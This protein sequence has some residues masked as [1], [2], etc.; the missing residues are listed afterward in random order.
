MIGAVISLG[1]TLILVTAALLALDAGSRAGDR[2]GDVTVSAVMG[3]AAQADGRLPVIVATVRNPGDAP[4]LVGL[5]ARR[6]RLPAWFDAGMSV[7]APRRTARRRL[8]A[9]RQKVVGVAGAGDT[10]LFHVPVPPRSRR[11]EL[12]AVVGQSGS[13]LRVM[14]LPVAPTPAAPA[15]PHK[16]LTRHE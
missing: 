1:V 4:V 7:S 8:S 9:S 5:S 6:R 2:H 11:C 10:A 12:V 16:P 13:R 14:S 15:S 3:S